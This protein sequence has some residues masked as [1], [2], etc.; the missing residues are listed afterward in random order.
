MHWWIALLFCLMPGLAMAQEGFDQAGLLGDW[1]QVAETPSIL[2]LDCH[3]T[4]VK[5]N[6][7]EDSRLE[8]RMAC[9]KGALDG[10]VVPIDG[11][12]VEVGPGIFQLRLVRLSHL[13]DLQLYV[14]DAQETMIV[15]GA[16]GYKVGWVWSREAQ[17]DEASLAKAEAVLVANG[18]MAGTI[19]WV[20]QAE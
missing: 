3:G 8:M 19:S 7:R 16:P 11:V 18:Y 15:L 12:V 20:E 6:T 17:P 13:G 10:P 4:T 5:I 14:L 9:H 2:N 1:F